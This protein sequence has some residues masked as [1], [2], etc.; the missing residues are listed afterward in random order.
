MDQN[1]KKREIYYN[2]SGNGKLKTVTLGLQKL[3]IYLL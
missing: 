2:F 3:N 1:M